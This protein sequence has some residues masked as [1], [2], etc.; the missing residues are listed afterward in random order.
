MLVGGGA[1]DP[2]WTETTGSGAPVRATSP[3]LVTPALGTPASGDLSNCT[4]AGGIVTTSVE[5]EAEIALDTG[6]TGRG[7][8]MAGDNEEYINFRFTAAG[9]CR[10]YLQQRQTP[11]TPIQTG[12]SASMMPGRESQSKTA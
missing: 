1:A 5:D 4:N 12:S 3:T 10:N 8:A 7:W 9:G 11:S 6:K 2:V